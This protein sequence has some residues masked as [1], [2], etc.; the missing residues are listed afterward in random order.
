MTPPGGDTDVQCAFESERALCN[1]V[2]PNHQDRARV[3]GILGQEQLIEF[4]SVNDDVG[5]ALRRAHVH[6]GADRGRAD[7][8]LP[9]HGQELRP[10]SR[11][12]KAREILHGQL[13]IFG[14]RKNVTMGTAHY[15]IYV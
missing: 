12:G 3:T 15:V 8:I 10:R 5:P 4:D 14:D 1:Q 7:K 2:S 9:V 6:D 13:G 11:R